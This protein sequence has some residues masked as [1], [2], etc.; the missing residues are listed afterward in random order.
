MGKV[1]DIKCDRHITELGPVV[2]REI[3]RERRGTRL[4]HVGELHDRPR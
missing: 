3:E 2:Q 4:K 1:W